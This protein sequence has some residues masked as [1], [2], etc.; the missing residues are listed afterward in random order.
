MAGIRFAQYLRECYAEHARSFGHSYH[1]GPTPTALTQ[2][3]NS[4]Q[5]TSAN[6]IGPTV[7]H[8]PVRDHLSR[9][10]HHPATHTMSFDEAQA[11]FK[12][13]VRNP[14][15][16]YLSTNPATG[17][18]FI[19]AYPHAHS[20]PTYEQSLTGPQLQPIIKTELSPTLPTPSIL[21]L[22]V[23][24][25]KYEPVSFEEWSLAPALYHSTSPSSTEY[26]ADSPSTPQDG[27]S[28]A[29]FAT[30]TDASMPSHSFHVAQHH[31]GSST[32]PMAMHEAATVNPLQGLPNGQILVPHGLPQ[33]GH[34]FNP[35]Q[36]SGAFQPQHHYLN[37][38][39]LSPADLEPGSPVSTV[40]D[41]ADDQSS[42]D[43]PASLDDNM[44]EG[45]IADR[46]T[47]DN[48]LLRLRAEGHSYKDLKRMGRFHEAESTLRGRHRTLT[49]DKGERVRKPQWRDQ[50]VRIPRHNFAAPSH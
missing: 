39:S 34:Y 40:E 25:S 42:S 11:W 30:H 9:P 41:F 45:S 22:H 24:T 27:F 8:A 10:F 15:H 37:N 14:E 23:D 28:N 5:R 44:L 29:S 49:K 46:R 7:Y 17:G 33:H 35:A 36:F 4:S 2:T 3:H 16:L 13:H 43:I 19:P 50:D 6:R 21:P 12:D 18:R 47:K 48:L 32:H 26:F 38:S 1:T 31:R 20:I